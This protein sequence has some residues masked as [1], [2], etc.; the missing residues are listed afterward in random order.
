MAVKRAKAEAREG[1]KP[2]WKP[3]FVLIV[4]NFDS[5]DVTG[6]C[7]NGSKSIQKGCQY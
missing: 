7:L 4:H 5:E 2:G 1:K 3:A 6:N